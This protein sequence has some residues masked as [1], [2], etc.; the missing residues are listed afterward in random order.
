MG[1][2][3]VRIPVDPPFLE[4]TMMDDKDIDIFYS[5]TIEESY[6]PC[7][8][9]GQCV[10]LGYCPNSQPKNETPQQKAS[11]LGVKVFEDIPKQPSPQNPNP[12]VGV[13]G[14][15]NKEIRLFNNY[16]PCFDMDC[17]SGICCVVPC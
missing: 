16:D 12:I 4:E 1:K 9:T 7:Y 6:S 11:R 13:C 8:C 5:A 2:T 15:C 3:G 17:P 10:G 14:R